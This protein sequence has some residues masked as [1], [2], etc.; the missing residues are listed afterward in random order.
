M[1]VRF[2]RR[3]FASGPRRALLRYENK[4]RAI[5]SLEAEHRLLSAASLK[6]RTQVLRNSII[7]GIALDRIVVPAFALVREASRRALGEVPTPEQL[8][9]GLAMHD[10]CIA[11]M[12]TGEGKTLAATL[13]CTLQALA[14]EGVHIAL[15]NDYL[16][17][18]DADW[19]RPVYEMLGLSVGLV[20]SDMDDA[21]RRDAYAC[22]V[23]YGVAS[24]FGFDYLR[25]NM[26]HTLA[27]TVQ[28]RLA[29]AL[30]DEADAVL[31]DEAV[32]P[33]ALYGPL[34]DQSGFYR[35]KN[36]A[37]CGNSRPGLQ[38]CP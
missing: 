10:G 36:P 33:L 23:T 9:A 6:Y 22:D 8:M 4:A 31:I 24:E 14:S 13:T 27:E 7:D 16:S 26:K 12:A 3:A 29:F 11:E 5:I 35:A 28:R 19:M 37:H 20:T 25:D 15:P 34:G 30:I 18:R 21:A 2:A 32:M 1:I 38:V 17:A